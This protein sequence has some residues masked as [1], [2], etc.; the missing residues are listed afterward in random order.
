MYKQYMDNPYT[1]CLLNAVRT[2]E[3]SMFRRAIGKRLV[4]S[5][6]TPPRN[7]GEKPTT[8]VKTDG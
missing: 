5:P 1:L 4:L 7:H 6:D 3:I 2:V 8:V